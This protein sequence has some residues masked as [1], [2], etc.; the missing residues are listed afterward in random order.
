MSRENGV[1]RRQLLKSIAASG[2]LAKWPALA[3]VSSTTSGSAASY[4]VFTPPQVTLMEA[5]V[6]QIVPADDFPGAKEAGAVRFIDHKL[7]GPYGRFFVARYESGLKEFSDVC[8]Q[9][10]H[11]EFASLDSGEQSHFLE[12]VAAKSHGE[13]LHEFFQT[14]ISDT[15]EGY[16]GT[17]EDGGNRDGA[18]W[19]MIG[20]Q[21]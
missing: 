15:F 3:A 20:F 14:V 12:D 19:K 9:Q 4:A 10:F 18:S 5:L 8:R 1:D 2:A 13:S 16:Y 11:R 17:P 6:E 21:G 7:G